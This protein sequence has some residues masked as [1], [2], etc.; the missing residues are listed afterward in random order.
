MHRNTDLYKKELITVFINPLQIIHV[1]GKVYAVPTYI[2]HGRS[3]RCIT[4]YDISVD[5]RGMR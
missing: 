1:T 3:Q 5:G 4:F 2:T